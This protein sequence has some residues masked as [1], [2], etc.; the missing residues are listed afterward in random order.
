MARFH[1]P[2]R[3]KHKGR[4]CWRVRILLRR[5]N[6]QPAR[7]AQWFPTRGAAWRFIEQSCDDAGEVTTD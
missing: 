5:S 7:F 4:E 1:A 3:T 6:G 2:E